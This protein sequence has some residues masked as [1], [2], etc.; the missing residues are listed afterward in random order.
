MSKVKAS[1]KV[2]QHSQAKRK[3]RRHGLKKSGGQAVKAGNIIL[4]QKGALYK[5][6]EGVDM[7]RDYTIFAL[8]DGNVR[9]GTRHGKTVVNV[10]PVTA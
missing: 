10:T 3:G 4:R 9:F 8:I 2:A 1:G 7:G 6:G 5:P